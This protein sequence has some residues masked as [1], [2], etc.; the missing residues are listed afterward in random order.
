MIKAI[1]TSAYGCRFR[2]RL[3]ARWATF[4]RRLEINW[5]YEAQGFRTPAGNYLPDFYLP[6]TE[7]FVEIKGAEPGEKDLAKCAAVPGLVLLVGDVPEIPE[8]ITFRMFSGC[9]RG[10]PHLL[11]RCR[12]GWRTFTGWPFGGVHAWQDVQAALTAARSARFEH[13]EHG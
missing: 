6:D 9:T 13:G 4:M 11:H 3:E 5:M 12:P 10:R 1:E 2:S 7:R 8:E